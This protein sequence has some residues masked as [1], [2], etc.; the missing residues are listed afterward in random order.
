MNVLLAFTLSLGPFYWFFGIGPSAFM[1]IKLVLLFC[2]IFVSVTKLNVRISKEVLIICLLLTSLKLISSYDHVLELSTLIKLIYPQVYIFFISVVFC[3]A[4]ENEKFNINKIF[5]YMN[6]IIFI[7]CLIIVISNI[8][9]MTI[10]SPYGIGT[11][12]FSGF[13][14]LRTGWSGGLAMFVVANLYYLTL[15][16]HNKTIFI[17]VILSIVVTIYTQYLSGGRGGLLASMLAISIFVLFNFKNNPIFYSSFIF[18]GVF[19]ISNIV[20]VNGVDELIRVNHDSGDISAGRIHQ[21]IVSM[22]LLAENYLLPMGYHGF[23]PRFISLGMEPIE[24]H[25]VWI[26]FAVQYSFMFVMIFVY[27]LGSR[28]FL[29]EVNFV[30]KLMI[31]CGL[32]PTLFEPSAILVNISNYIVW[33]FVFFT[34]NYAISDSSSNNVIFKRAPL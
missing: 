11:I 16:K 33:W 30:G 25:N 31:L 2:L 3:H 1:L 29:S 24:I 6:V 5:I 20:L 23:I 10:I 22:S 15:C 28:I 12:E 8:I 14:S 9:G 17:G 34:L 21:Y 19:S 18:C 13:G 32:I 26:G 7:S 4:I 27:F